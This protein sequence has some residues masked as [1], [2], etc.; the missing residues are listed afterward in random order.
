MRRAECVGTGHGCPGYRARLLGSR[1]RRGRRRCRVAR[2]QQLGCEIEKRDA[3]VPK[4]RKVDEARLDGTAEVH[5]YEA[6]AGQVI[7]LPIS[8]NR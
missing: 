7:D 4:P 8:E 5:V 2:I 6:D 1:R 3:G